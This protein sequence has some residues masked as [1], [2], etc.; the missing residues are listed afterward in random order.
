MTRNLDRLLRTRRIAD[1]RRVMGRSLAAFAALGVVFA[2]VGVVD[3]APAVAAGA[4]SAVTVAW[5]GQGNDPSIQVL[6]PEREH[7]WLSEQKGLDRN[8]HYDDFKDL[9]VTVSKTAGVRDEAV[10]IEVSGMPGGT[11]GGQWMP[12]IGG[13]GWYSAHQQSFLQVMQC[14]GDPRADDFRET[15]QWGAHAIPE[16]NINDTTVA[17]YRDTPQHLI[18]FRSVQ[19]DDYVYPNWVP[20]GAASMGEILNS[21]TTNELLAVPVKADGSTSF[22]FE[23]QSTAQAPW[24]GCGAPAEDGEARRCSLVIVPRGTVY[25]GEQAVENNP[26]VEYGQ[27]GIQRGAP[28]SLEHDYWD[29]RIVVPLDVEAPLTACGGG[30]ARLVGGSEMLVHAM[31]SWQSA[32]C[33]SGGP[34]FNFTA[35]ADA[36]S[37][38]QLAQGRLGLAY[39]ARGVVPEELG[40][41][42]AEM[43]EGTDLA[44][45][46]VAVSGITVSFQYIGAAGPITDLRLTPRLL[47]KLLT[48]SYQNAVPFQSG[49]LADSDRRSHL[50]ARNPVD[51]TYDPEFRDLNPQIG[52]NTVNLR[53]ADV[54]VAG[55]TGSD[56]YRL[57]WEYLQADEKARAFLAG[58]PDNVLPG[59]GNN[60]G[61]TINPYYLPKGHPGAHVPQYEEVPWGR[62]PKP[63]ETE[64]RFVTGPDGQPAQRAVGFTDANG[65]PLSLADTPIDTI[66]RADEHLAPGILRNG[67]PSRFDSVA[68]NPYATNLENVARRVFRADVQRPS[69]DP[70]AWTG[71][72]NGAW[73]AVGRDWPPNVRILGLTDTPAA[74]QFVLPTARLQLP[75]RPGVFAGPTEAAL[76]AAVGAQRDQGGAS[77][78][79]VAALPDDAY[80]LT[81]VSYAAVNLTASDADARA[82]YADLIE[83]AVTDG[84]VPGESPGQLPAG[85]APL[86]DE[87]R[88]QALEAAQRIRDYVAPSDD[89]PGGVG[90][91][92]QA[93]AGVPASGPGAGAAG[94][95]DPAGDAPE[96]QVSRTTLDA[97]D[98]AVTPAAAAPAGVGGALL[99]SLAAGAAAPFLLRRRETG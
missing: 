45:A 19:G 7:T 16:N 47:A 75:N 44:Y 37:R 24:L 91:D 40:E 8:P 96:T 52:T 20:D 22:A 83:Y 21:S 63:G 98:A 66:P 73:K 9:Q 17:G 82:D 23:V 69:W 30:S 64:L 68:Y 88:A 26:R 97:A 2:G 70:N 48:Q 13:D 72:G 71:S 42:G 5:N 50:N 32:L 46:P 56:G 53:M 33:A 58:E 93:A 62:N 11:V 78:A 90:P 35:N 85:Y 86:S 4:G 1:R 28:T 79:D 89:A 3:A 95:G 55:P 81:L 27:K 54:V 87:L 51:V 94:A 29:N 6:Q 25:G 99:A 39:T 60:L 74:E 65:A 38:A 84:Q 43:L 12:G 61:M 77:W 31:G 76:T 49:S 59:D 14:W 41:G 57:L 15:C 10:R 80:P 34:A 92:E 67:V 18:P 36:Q